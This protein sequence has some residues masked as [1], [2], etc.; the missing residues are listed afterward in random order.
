MAN[1]KLINYIKQTL[2]QGYSPEEIRRVLLNSGWKE[3]QI[4]EAFDLIE[5]ERSG[6]SRPPSVFIKTKK[7][8]FARNK[9]LIIAVF[10]AIFV[11]GGLIFVSIT[12]KN[13]QER[14][15][16]SNYQKTE[17]SP[18]ILEKPFVQ[19]FDNIAFPAADGQFPIPKYE[20]M[21]AIM[22]DDFF[23]RTGQAEFFLYY[24]I[25]GKHKEDVREFYI[26]ALENEG[27]KLEADYEINEMQ[28]FE[29]NQIKGVFLSFSK[30]EHEL[31]NAEITI[32]EDKLGDIK[33]D[34]PPEVTF[35]KII[36]NWPIGF[37]YAKDLTPNSPFCQYFDQDFRKAFSFI[38]ELVGEVR[39]NGLHEI[40]ESSQQLPIRIFYYV[41]QKSIASVED[42]NKIIKA[43]STNGYQANWTLGKPIIM[44]KTVSGKKYSFKMTP[45]EEGFVIDFPAE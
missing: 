4:K 33:E 27:W 16:L 11:I 7:N 14:V 12:F 30:P 36:E 42:I 1:Q 28:G 29:G 10:G 13:N 31:Y 41:T 20:K 17:Q 19:D 8:F 25:G 2:N 26:R 15:E 34:W 43:F 24:I 32:F 37:N 39:L 44:S 9:N 3:N 21:K 23:G 18:N 40:S 45:L 38:K 35:V 5:Q 6:I 22:I